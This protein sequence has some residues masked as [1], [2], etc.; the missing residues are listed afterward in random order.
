MNKNRITYDNPIYKKCLERA[1]RL[2]NSEWR[3]APT[4][5]YMNILKHH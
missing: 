4:K 5:H 3:N 2:I 1:E